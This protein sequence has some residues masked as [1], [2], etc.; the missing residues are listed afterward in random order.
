MV[1]EEGGGGGGSGGLGEGERVEVGAA[2][3]P[4]TLPAD[5]AEQSGSH[6]H[7]KSP[8]GA[9]FSAGAAKHRGLCSS[10]NNSNQKRTEGWPSRVYIVP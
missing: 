9:L 7:G 1:E 10:N 4:Y 8:V 6:H 5:W 2:R 3:G